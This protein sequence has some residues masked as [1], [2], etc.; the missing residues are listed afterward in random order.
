VFTVGLLAG[1][2][3]T[4]TALW[5][6]SGLASAVP[7]DWRY[8]VV[9]VVAVLAALRDADVLWIP[10]PQNARQVP[11]DVLQRHLLR[12]SLQFGFELGTGVR[13]YVTASAAYVVAIALL[14]VGDGYLDALLTGVGFGLGRAAT[15]LMRVASGSG[16][17]WDRTM[18]RRLPLM[19]VAGCAV[20]AVVFAILLLR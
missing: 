6:L 11:Q 10:M 18:G 7:L 15:P 17:A 19:T 3:C 4:A 14:L 1:G 2:V 8:G 20:L 13:T 9:V 12:G 16:D 5:L